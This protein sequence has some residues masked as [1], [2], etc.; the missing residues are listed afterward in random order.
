MFDLAAAVADLTRAQ[1]FAPTLRELAGR[2]GTNVARAA[3]LANGARERG[4]VTFKDQQ[5]R[6]IRVVEKTAVR[7]KRPARG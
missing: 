1:G 7:R 3:F 6:T 2:L 4:L 5:A